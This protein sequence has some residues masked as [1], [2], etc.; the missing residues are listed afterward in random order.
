MSA[1][2]LAPDEEIPRFQIGV[3]ELPALLREFQRIV[4]ENPVAAQR[5]FAAFVAEGRAFAKTPAG[6]QW[7]ER[8]SQS[9]LVHRA[10]V[11]WDVVTL[12]MLEPDPEVVLP[13]ALL[14]AFVRAAAV[15]GLEPMLSRIYE[16]GLF[17]D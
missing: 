9:E 3:D 1:D 12:R 17:N 8:L 4:L 7:H 5:L 6:Q 10:R 13:G 15:D 2:R 11:T 14:D 16:Q